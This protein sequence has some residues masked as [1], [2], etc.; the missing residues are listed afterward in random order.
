MFYHAAS[1][2]HYV[3][4]QK[5]LCKTKSFKLTGEEKLICLSKNKNE[6]PEAQMEQNKDE[7][8]SKILFGIIA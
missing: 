7:S 1:F 4:I 8:L 5:F 2:I 6:E 3:F